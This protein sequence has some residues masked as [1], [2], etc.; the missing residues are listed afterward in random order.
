MEPVFKHTPLYRFLLECGAQG[1]GRRVLDCGAGGDTPPLALFALHGY[2]V[3]GVE[4]DPDQL[5]KARAFA[6]RQGLTLALQPGDMRAL[7]FA[8]GSFD[9]V[10]SYNSVF[11]MPKEQVAR[12]IGE[13]KRVLK[14]GGLLFVNFLSVRDFRC[15]TGG[16]LGRNQY[17]QEDDGLPVVH[18][19]YT[20]TEANPF[21]AEM[22]LLFKE[23]RVQERR[24]E[25]E[26][27]RQGFV[28][29]IARKQ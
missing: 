18:S 23:C 19:Y 5:E 13:M 14:P 10:Y 1:D 7:P 27:I 28:D 4:L 8:D 11:H 3:T 24:Y 12:A 29:Y 16:D 22:E 9:V 2:D 21:F 26:W 6:A 20:E 15:G 17:E 25:G